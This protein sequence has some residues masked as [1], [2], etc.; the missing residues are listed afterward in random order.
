MADFLGLTFNESTE[1]GKAVKLKQRIKKEK[2][3]LIIVNDIWEE[4][5]LECLGIP[6]GDEH[7]G[8]KL[9]L[10]SR[11]MNVLKSEMGIQKAFQLEVLK[12]YEARSLFEKMAGDVV[13]DRQAIATEIV[14][15]CAGLPVLI[16]TITNALRNKEVYVWK[17][18][19]KRLQRFDRQGMHQKVYLAVEL[20]YNY[21]ESEEKSLF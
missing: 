13:K 2:S 12:E 9:L 16:V 14:K 5:E 20:S 21:L 6:L 3:I 1:V 8:C 18:A 11:N 10:T 15:R 17:D 7:K 4:F 19:L